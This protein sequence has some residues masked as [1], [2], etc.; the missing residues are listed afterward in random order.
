MLGPGRRS[1][2]LPGRG[3]GRG[4]RGG[5]GGGPGGWR[6]RSGDPDDQRRGERRT[7]TVLAVLLLVSFLVITLDARRPESSP[8][9]GLRTVAGAVFGPLET[10]AAT[11]LSPLTG[12]TGYFGDV[13]RLRAANETL[14]QENDRL[15]SQLR[16]DAFARQRSAELDRLLDLGRSRDDRLVPA[17][18][19]AMGGGQTFTRTVTIDA[20]RDDG[21]HPDM[22]VLNAQGLVGRVIAASGSTA[23]V[24]LLID[25]DSVVGGRLGRSSE[26]GFIS[27][28]GD[29]GEHARLRM[30]LVDRATDPQD[31]DT[32][33]TWGSQGGAPYVAGVPIGSVDQVITSPRELSKTVIVEPFVDYSA[34][35]M[36][37]VV[38]GAERPGRDRAAAQG[39]R[40]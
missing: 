6:G 2:G 13:S 4:P 5:P 10:G 34:L 17:Q 37:G 28:Q 39:R 9:D 20:G 15:R 16:T 12:V 26:L 1:G 35:D 8:V 18:V 38:V 22:T 14:H 7:R 3:P 11:V 29:I 31:G 21:V 24:L 23:T 27:G 25:P 30:Q 36:V 33:V 32:V 19:T 40:R